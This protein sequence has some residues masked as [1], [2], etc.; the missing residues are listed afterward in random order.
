MMPFNRSHQLKLHIDASSKAETSGTQ[1]II[2]TEN[3]YLGGIYRF[4]N[5]LISGLI[6]DGLVVSLLLNA[7][8]PEMNGAKNQRFDIANVTFYK[9]F[10]QGK[11]FSGLSKIENCYAF[12]NLMNM[13]R[14][15][16]EVAFLLRQSLWFTRYFR[17][18][19]DCYDVCLVISGGF[20]GGISTRAAIIGWRMANPSKKL[21]LNIHGMV[22]KSRRGFKKFDE[23]IDKFVLKRVNQ[24][25]TVS[26]T[27]KQSFS[28]RS[29]FRIICRV[30]VIHNAL[31][32]CD[33]FTDR[34]GNTLTSRDR[35]SF[36]LLLLGNY[37][38]EK[39]HYWL[40]SSLLLCK[41]QGYKVEL[42][43]AG[44]DKIGLKNHLDR[45]VKDKNLSSQIKFLDFHADADSLVSGCDALVVPSLIDESFCLSLLDAFR[46][47][48]PI[49]GSNS[50]AIGE[51]SVDGESSLLVEKG[52]IEGLANAIISLASNDELYDRLCVGSALS[53]EKYDYR[54][55]VGEYARRLN[56]C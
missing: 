31:A 39:G 4:S 24:I 55:M 41:E 29:S 40:L 18:N 45:Y 17:E 52:D 3:F 38:I 43:C 32:N 50:G 20:P 30:D 19:S 46:F 21:I 15:F 26:E 36:S 14:K 49:I 37:Q 28:N 27:C 54:S 42:V 1:V 25:I 33:V 2:V 8:S 23:K 12:R 13:F 48:K 34:V 16:F 7:N 56:D 22:Q 47:G 44:D 6:N 51:I 11:L 53:L 9:F 10:S 5:D 35:R